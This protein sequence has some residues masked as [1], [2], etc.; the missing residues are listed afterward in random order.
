MR[1]ILSLNF[2]IVVLSFLPILLYFSILISL[3]SQILH[4]ST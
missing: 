4:L 3:D 2:N 1:F